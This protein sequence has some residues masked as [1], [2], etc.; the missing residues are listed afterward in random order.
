MQVCFVED[1]GSVV[2]GHVYK[3]FIICT[4][5]VTPICLWKIQ[6][7]VF[8]THLKVRCTSEKLCKVWPSFLKT[9]LKV[10][11]TSEKIRKVWPFNCVLDPS[12]MS[13][14]SI[15]VCVVDDPGAVV[16]GR[17][18]NTWKI[19]SCAVTPIL[20]RKFV[21]CLGERSGWSRCRWHKT[22]VY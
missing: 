13:R 22:C 12:S 8:K 21:F 17:A 1:R 20:Q 4:C 11:W 10:G 6:V 19:C 2:T 16:K 3:K 14:N 18:Y 7:S 15:W 9:P 5:D